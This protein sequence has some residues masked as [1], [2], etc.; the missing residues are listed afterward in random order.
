MKVKLATQVLSYIVDVG[1]ATSI[2]LGGNRKMPSCAIGTAD[3]CEEMNILF[4]IFNS[5]TN[6]KG[7]W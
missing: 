1:L 5:S 3:F 2:A 7:S 4:D 6:V